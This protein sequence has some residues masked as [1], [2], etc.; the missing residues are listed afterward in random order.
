M[1]QAIRCPRDAESSDAEHF[2]IPR[3]MPRNFGPNIPP[4]KIAMP[5]ERAELVLVSFGSG[6]VMVNEEVAP[7]AVSSA[8][9]RKRESPTASFY[10]ASLTLTLITTF[11]TTHPS[12][13]RLLPIV[14]LAC[15][16][17]CFVNHSLFVLRPLSL[18][19]PTSCPPL[20]PDTMS[21]SEPLPYDAVRLMAAYPPY[22]ATSTSGRSN[23]LRSDTTPRTESSS[24][25]AN[26]G[27]LAQR[28]ASL[29]SSQK[30][31]LIGAQAELDKRLLEKQHEFDKKLQEKEQEFDKKLLRK[32]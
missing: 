16:S 6:G 15:S 30:L 21:S 19:T 32:Q 18:F 12:S 22:T 20:G 25:S 5:S 31:V 17:S 27:M 13:S 10:R 23:S 4:D 11:T 28:N 9:P 8:R 24:P 2:S 14:S 3:F 29:E 26:S 7:A 1:F